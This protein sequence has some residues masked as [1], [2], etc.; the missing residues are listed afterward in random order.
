[1]SWVAVRVRWAWSAKPASKDARAIGLTGNSQSLLGA[2]ASSMI[3]LHLIGGQPQRLAPR[4]H[5]SR[6]VGRLFGRPKL[7]CIGHELG[8]DLA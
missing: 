7:V 8:T 3:Q 2:A 6:G 1:M 5:S 4:V